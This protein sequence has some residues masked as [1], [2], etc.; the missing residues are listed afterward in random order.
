MITFEWCPNGHTCPNKQPWPDCKRTMGITITLNSTQG[1]SMLHSEAYVERMMTESLTVGYVTD[2]HGVQ[3]YAPKNMHF[4]IHKNEAEHGDEN[5]TH[6]W[7]ASYAGH[8]DPD[9]LI[10]AQLKF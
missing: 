6:S 2:Q 1:A 5:G 7:T 9:T 10:E 3:H 8:V 4:V